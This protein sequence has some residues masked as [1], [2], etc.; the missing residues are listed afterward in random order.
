MPDEQ[1]LK[2]RG[3]SDADIAAIRDFWQRQQQKQQ[4]PAAQ[5]DQQGKPAHKMPR[6]PWEFL[7]NILTT[8]TLY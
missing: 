8:G 1:A 6:S 7:K 2:A 3:Y 5:Q 4:E